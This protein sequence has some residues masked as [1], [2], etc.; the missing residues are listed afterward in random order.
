MFKVFDQKPFSGKHFFF[1]NGN[2]ISDRHFIIY[3]YSHKPK[4]NLCLLKETSTSLEHFFTNTELNTTRAQLCMIS[5]LFTQCCSVQGSRHAEG[6]QS[7]KW[8]RILWFNLGTATTTLFYLCDHN[9][10]NSGCADSGLGLK[11]SI[12]PPV[13]LT[14]TTT[15][16]IIKPIMIIVIC[17]SLRAEIQFSFQV[18]QSVCL[19]CTLIIALLL[20]ISTF[21]KQIR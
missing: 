10:S 13:A 7:W 14:F 21:L 15:H 20:Y 2:F 16:C 8:W 17:Y 12:V 4:T 3:D 5:R 19:V 6:R 18:C 9:G 1:L 11:S